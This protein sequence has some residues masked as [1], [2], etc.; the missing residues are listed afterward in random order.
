M[1][2]VVA[3][4]PRRRSAGGPELSLTL[5]PSSSTVSWAAVKVKVLEVSPLS[6]VTLSGTPESAVVAPPWLVFS[7]GMTTVRSGSASRVTVTLR[8]EP[9]GTK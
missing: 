1:D 5:S 7:M 6:K 4:V 2:G 8:E 9:S 3:G